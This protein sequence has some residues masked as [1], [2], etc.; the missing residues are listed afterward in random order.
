M[1]FTRKNKGKLQLDQASS[2]DDI[3]L[4]LL[5]AYGELHTLQA[6]AKKF[7]TSPST[8]S[9]WYR[10]MGLHT[11]TRGR[12]SNASPPDPGS[13]RANPRAA[14]TQPANP[15]KRPPGGKLK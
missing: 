7:G 1:A 8:M 12:P 2:L 14:Q 6:V 5:E 9:V 11:G 13:G 3:R 15:K 10:E 4:V